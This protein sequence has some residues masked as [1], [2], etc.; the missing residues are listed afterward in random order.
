MMIQ[1]S[2]LRTAEAPVAVRVS[3]DP[4]VDV[5]A[6]AL[7]LLLLLSRVVVGDP[8]RA[9]STSISAVSDI[10]AGGSMVCFEELL[11]GS[12]GLGGG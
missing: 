9:T 1:P 12:T 8:S 2:I 11:G 10:V 3:A 7:L 4:V 6:V 5:V